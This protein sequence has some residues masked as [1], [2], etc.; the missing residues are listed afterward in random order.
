MELVRSLRYRTESP[1]MDCISALRESNGDMDGAIALL[2]KKGAARAVKKADRCTEHGFVMGCKGLTP[3][4]GAA[5]VTV[6]SETDFAARSARFAQLCAAV[7]DCLL[8]LMQDSQAEGHLM[9]EA[10]EMTQ[11]LR[12]KSASVVQ[13]A[14]AVLGENIRVASVLPI[15]PA[16]HHTDWSRLHVGM[17]V[18]GGVVADSEVG[19]FVGLAMVHAAQPPQPELLTA[20]ARHFVATS[21][22]EGSYLQESFVGGLNSETTQQ[23]MR[24]HGMQLSRSLV[25][26][27]GKEAVEHV[28]TAS[29]G[30]RTSGSATHEQKVQHAL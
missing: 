27:F 28:A 14:V 23:W 12:E 5:I 30:V 7:R 10:A 19:R 15:R 8:E 22:S 16:P 13:S 24:R 2:Q 18:H 20:L 6:C 21:G 25:Q 9:G 1:M 3:S 26:E 11:R 29:C 4:A 17:Y